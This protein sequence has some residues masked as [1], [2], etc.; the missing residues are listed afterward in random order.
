MQ[1]LLQKILIAKQVQQPKVHQYRISFFEFIVAMNLVKTIFSI[2][3][4]VSNYLQS[5][6]IDFI[7][8]INL[9]DVAKNRLIDPRDD[10]KS[11]I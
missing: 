3:T 10:S 4:P 5:K 1:F 9:I 7:E 6:S 2:T 11:Q 8:A